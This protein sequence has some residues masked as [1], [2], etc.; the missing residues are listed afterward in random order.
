MS[1]PTYDLQQNQESGS[2][3]GRRQFGVALQKYT[4]MIGNSNITTADDIKEYRVSPAYR[5]FEYAFA[6]LA[7]K[8]PKRRFPYEMVL[9][10]K[11]LQTCHENGGIPTR[12]DKPTG[13]SKAQSA[14]EFLAGV[15]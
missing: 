13:N 15:Q 8:M 12:A 5:G 11:V 6:Q 9:R 1:P 10:E 2:T 3:G 7:E 14:L 4:A